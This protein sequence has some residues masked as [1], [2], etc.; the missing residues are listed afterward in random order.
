MSEIEE[1]KLKMSD[2]E[3]RIVLIEERLGT[4]AIPVNNL[5]KNISI[6]EFLNSR[7]PSND[8]QKTLLIMYFLEQY[9]NNSSINID[10]IRTGFRNAKEPIPKNISDKIYM[11][12]KKG[13]VME[14]NEKKDKKNCFIIT[15]TGER[16]V[17]S[18]L[19]E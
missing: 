15:N 17:D 19:K 4:S 14:T 16:F 1:L 7:K 5:I 11:S 13:Y 3:N 9:E 12:I 6:R 18:K 8:V 2:L 10:D